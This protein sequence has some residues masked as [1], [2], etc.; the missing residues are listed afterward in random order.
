METYYTF[1]V[2]FS[3]CVYFV[4]TDDNAARLVN[5]RFMELWVTIR[6]RWFIIMMY[7]RIKYDSW[8]M[9]RY[10]KKLQSETHGRENKT[11]SGNSSG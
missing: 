7:P 1:L 9:K 4:I 8:M 10:L 6:R 2:L 11:N 5:L 3:I